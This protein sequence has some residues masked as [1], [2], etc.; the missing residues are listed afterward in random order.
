MFPVFCCFLFAP[1]AFLVGRQ[2]GVSDLC[3][4]GPCFGGELPAVLGRLRAAQHS[5]SAKDPSEATFEASEA[6][7]TGEFG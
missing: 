4:V 3:Q 5:G 2:H 1:V 6:Y 7:S